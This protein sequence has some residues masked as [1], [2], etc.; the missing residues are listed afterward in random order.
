MPPAPAR[1]AARR[2]LQRRTQLRR[3]QADHVVAAH[4]TDR[5]EPQQAAGGDRLLAELLVRAAARHG[6]RL[7]HKRLERRGAPRSCG[8]LLVEDRWRALSAGAARSRP[9]AHGGPV[10]HSYGGDPLA[11]PARP[12][13][14]GLNGPTPLVS[15]RRR[16]GDRLDGPL[17]AVGAAL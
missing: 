5:F 7:L 6:D 9:T 4:R 11:D 16:A 14:A 15:G 10:L 8:R 1:Q 12:L 17:G 13:S 3:E 2:H